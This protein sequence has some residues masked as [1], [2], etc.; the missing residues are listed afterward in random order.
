MRFV[1]L[2]VT[3]TGM[4]LSCR[5]ER[6]FAGDESVV[7]SAESADQ[8]V[9]EAPVVP[10]EQIQEFE[11]AL[12]TNSK[13]D[14]VWLIDNSGSMSQ[15]ANQVR[16]NL[17]KFMASIAAKV[18]V[19]VTL[20]SDDKGP[21][22]VRLSEE[23]LAQGHLQLPVAVGSKD[24]LALLASSLCPADQTNFPLDISDLNK[25]EVE[26]LDTIIDS[27]YKLCNIGISSG[28]Y[29]KNERGIPA[30]NGKVLERLRPDSTK[31]F[32]VVTDDDVEGPVTDQ[33]LLV[34]T[35]L[36]ASS[37][38]A[39][40]FAGKAS[41]SGC[42]ISNPGIPYESLSEATNGEVFDICEADWS[43]N[44]SKLSDNVIQLASNRFKLDSK[45]GSKILRVTLDGVELPIDAYSFDEN[46]VQIKDANSLLSGKVL[47]VVYS[48][49]Q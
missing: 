37:V 27:P 11:I 35:D 32:V 47:S 4:L 21:F 22:G 14:M 23:A 15:E 6:K 45:P 7:S 19:K 17:E 24:A 31:V 36:P 3:I 1:L 34:L 10:E 46:I 20:I 16:L 12:Q 25:F 29:L 2:S 43:G 40:A 48:F 5:D 41:R 42:I 38:R 30:L 9:V 39:F 18:D 44:F 13:V 26:G 33:N 28:R 49:E 8:E